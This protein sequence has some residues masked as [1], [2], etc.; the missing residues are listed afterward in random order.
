[1]HKLLAAALCAGGVFFS[2]PGP[3][4]ACLWDRDTLLMERLRF[5]TALEL[6]TGKFLRHSEAFYR[7]R[8]ADRLAKLKADPKAIAYYDD[9][10]A[11]Y[12]KTGDQTRAIVTMLLKEGISPGRYETYANLG[13]FYAHAGDLET[14]VKIIDIAIKINPD[15]HFGRE[16]YQKLLAEYVLSVRKDGALALPLSGRDERD[17]MSPRGYGFDRFLQGKAPGGQKAVK[18]VLGMM[19]FGNHES[20]ILLEALGDL[21]LGG[22]ASPGVLVKT[23]A[24]QLA[25]R[26][27]L[28]ASY[29]VKD[30]G[31]A[32]AYR[33]FAANAIMVH[34]DPRGR[35]MTVQ[36]VQAALDREIEEA[37]A[38][39][40][41]VAADEATWIEQ[42]RDPEAAFEAK[43]YSRQRAAKEGPIH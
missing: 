33:S 3:A 6:I 42:G 34:L 40:A 21:L 25:A 15:A 12:D 29:H 41:K 2:S 23:D 26:A 39:Y 37:K 24:R 30:A 13:T 36:E 31:A 1:M 27:Y 28:K 20:P 17:V 8:I 11:A 19:R 16:I 22:G 14:G 38:W 5:P 35:E 10:A 32:A 4:A 9:L 43:Y 7:W 18:G